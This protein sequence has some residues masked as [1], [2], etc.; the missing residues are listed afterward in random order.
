MK[1]N[2]DIFVKVNYKVKGIGSE[3]RCDARINYI[4]AYEAS[5]YAIGGGFS[6]RDACSFVFKAQ[7]FAEAKKIIE[8]NPIL[9]RWLSRY[10]NIK[11]DITVVP[12]F[13]TLN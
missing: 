1:N 4:Y 11:Y 7:D 9:R 10:K 3:F 12:A 5:K 13:E 8:A 6:N 2:S